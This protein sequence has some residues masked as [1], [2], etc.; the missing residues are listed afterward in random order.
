MWI[1]MT[2]EGPVA[3]NLLLEGILDEDAKR[4]MPGKAE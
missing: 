3:C 1:T 2:E 4:N